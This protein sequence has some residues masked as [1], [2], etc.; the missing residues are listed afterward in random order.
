MAQDGVFVF[1][2]AATRGAASSIDPDGAE[3]LMFNRWI[4][5]MKWLG[6]PIDWSEFI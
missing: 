1:P 4:A 2:D 6:E 3:G 5:D